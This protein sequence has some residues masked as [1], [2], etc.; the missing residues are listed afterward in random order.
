MLLLLCVFA[1]PISAEEARILVGPN[2]LVSRDGDIPHTELIAAA[3]PQNAKNLIAAG[4]TPSSARGS[5]ATK[6]YA[7][8]D[9]GVTWSHSSFPELHEAG[10]LD[11][12]VGYGPQGTAYFSAIRFVKDEKGQDRAGLLFYRSEDNGRTWSKP[13][14]MGFS[15]D[16]PIMG[17][18][19]TTGA[20]A[21]RIYLSV[22]YGYP[23]YTVGVFRSEDDGRTFTGPVEAA[24]GGG[25]IG[26]NTISNVVILRDGTLLIPYV[27]FEF[28]PEKSKTQNALNFWIVSSKD[29][30]I[31]FSAPQKIGAQHVNN[32]PE[33]LKFF[34]VATAAADRS[35]TFPDR[36]YLVWNDFRSGKYRMMISYSSDRGRTW[37][38]AA[39]VDPGAPAHA[40]QF[41]PAVA[42][43]KD[44]VL[45]I[46]W[47]DSR[48]SNDESRYDEYFTASLDGG[49]SFLPPVRVS[50]ESSMPAGGANHTL[51]P[52]IYFMQGKLMMGFM[53]AY[54]RWPSG[55]DYMGLTADRNGTFYP[56]WAD[57]RTGTFQMQTAFVKVIKEKTGTDTSVPSK[58]QTDLTEKVQ[59]LFDPAKYDPVTKT[60]DIPIHIKNTSGQTIYGPLQL[61]LVSFGGDFEWD[62]KEEIKKNAPEILNAA[63]GQ[64]GAGAT[65]DF[66]PA[67]GS[68]SVLENG[69]V[70]GAIIWRMK[71]VG[72][73]GKVPQLR[74]KV[75]GAAEGKK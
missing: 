14:D 71:L 21:G 61:E 66:T 48:N 19:Q 40:Q 73:P 9:G 34:G 10:A 32:T 45:G 51:I 55:G 53:S 20:Y 30:G 2:I 4:I 28:D 6:T 75:T 17:V 44:G 27:D 70:S 42:V 15:Y 25:K 72:D 50:S 3:D 56:V 8:V 65:F 37:S 46:T 57:S 24:N 18:D 23:V 26:I 12:Q 63:N 59:I 7:S 22:L 49:K 47:F 64:K 69:A 67:L 74:L 35:N 60:I 58:A 5:W 11:P 68:E 39:P 52:D 43:N 13:V 54:T 33:G 38:A 62:D 36:I 16:H 29:G 1:A 31:T 41:Q